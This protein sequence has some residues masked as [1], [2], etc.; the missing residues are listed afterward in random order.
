M[1]RGEISLLH[2]Q[3]LSVLAQVGKTENWSNSNVLGLYASLIAL[4]G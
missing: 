4:V 2:F 1:E 3:Y